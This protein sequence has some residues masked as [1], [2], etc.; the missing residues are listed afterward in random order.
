M[1]ETVTLK[2][3]EARQADTILTVDEIIIGKD[4]LELVSSAMYVD[5]LTVYREY[6]QNAADA[7]DEARA[8]GLLK[9]GTAG[10]VAIEIDN[11]ARRIKIRDNGTG[12][13]WAEFAKR[14]TAL[15][16]SVKRGGACR[17]FRGVGRLAGLG[18][19]QQLIFRSRAPGEKVVSQLVWDCKALRGAL[20]SA[21]EDEGVGHL[22]RRLVSL[23]KI[24]ADGYPE[25]FFEV[26]MNGI[27][28]LRSDKLLSP[29][30]VAEYLGQVAPVPF[31]PDFPFAAVVREA[32]SSEVNLGELEI[33]VS[34]L[35]EPVYRPHRNG[36]SDDKRECS[37]QDIEIFRIPNVDGNA[38][39]VGWVLHHEYDGAIP[40]G[41]GFKGLRLRSGNVQI[42]ANLLLEELFTEARFN[43]W[44]VGEFHVLD[45]R[46]V[47]NARRDDFEQNAHYSNLVNQ[48]SP[49]ARS[50]SKR[51]RISS[52]RRQLLRQFRIH[53]DAVIERINILKQRAVRRDG[54]KAQ[55]A[56]AE[57]S[58]T[59]MTRF[60]QRSELVDERPRLM[61][62][63][64]KLRSRIP[65]LTPDG[66][67]SPLALLPPRKRSLY[68]QMFELIYDCA[69]SRVAAKALVDR[70]LER[71]QGLDP[72]KPRKSKRV[73][74]RTTP[75]KGRSS[76]KKGR[77][78]MR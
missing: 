10:T 37:F 44:S 61:S 52:K 56:G 43:S 35:A 58:L 71:I 15:G 54:R 66:E 27:V 64:D 21:D 25:H 18:Y 11:D 30:A 59:R 46:I 55:I 74:R 3:T 41:T 1:R 5:P 32:L 70:I 47:P 22:I 40:N 69:A 17:G 76:S 33:R 75:T 48:L 24:S 73:E 45:R 31:C 63:I 12:L 78:R 77:R 53:E 62:R 6:V 67:D 38:A 13:A 9:P 65:G 39:A 51:C 34:G 19:S 42:G 72:T 16:G 36:F 4:V 50:I 23:T 68:G 57:N 26:E 60:S 2:A 20:R 29:V 8:S 14:L 28:R 7:I 49:I